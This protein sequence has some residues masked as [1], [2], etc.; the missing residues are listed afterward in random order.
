MRPIVS[1]PSGSSN[2]SSEP[3]RSVASHSVS[4][5]QYTSASGSYTSTRPPAKPKVW[6]P[7]DSRATLP[8]S[9]IRSA[10][11]SFLPYFFLTGHSSRRD[12]SRLT[13]SGQLFSGA[14]R[15]CPAPA[16]APAVAQPVGARGVPGH[17]DEQPRVAAEVSRPPVLGVG[18]HRRDVG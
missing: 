1:A 11:E 14:K 16:P 10:Q 5:P 18:Q 12:L 6:K 4:L 8:A 9:T 7:P 3:Q 17:P 13:L 2:L 15:C